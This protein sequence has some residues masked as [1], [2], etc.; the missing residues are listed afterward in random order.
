MNTQPQWLTIATVK[1]GA[2]S[3]HQ[4]LYF[5]DLMREEMPDYLII[6]TAELPIDFSEETY[7]ISDGQLVPASGD[8][9]AQRQAAATIAY[10]EQQRVLRE[11]EYR[12]VTD[13]K[14]I[15]LLADSTP[16]IA[17]LKDEIR[18]KYPYKA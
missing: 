9:I 14:V 6:P 2:L 15:E 3:T 12:A 10:N 13:P 18:K 16:E 5:L 17:V 4:R 8:V 7:T 11:S 1:D